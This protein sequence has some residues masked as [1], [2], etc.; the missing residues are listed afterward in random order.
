MT[1][2]YPTV[3][4]MQCHAHPAKIAATW[5]GEHPGCAALCGECA[6]EDKAS[7]VAKTALLPIYSRFVQPADRYLFDAADHAMR[8][9]VTA[10]EAVLA[11]FRETDALVEVL[12]MAPWGTLQAA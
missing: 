4:C 11:V 5:T 3:L 12:N 1:R 9:W 7:R 8:V 2:S 6:V 10:D